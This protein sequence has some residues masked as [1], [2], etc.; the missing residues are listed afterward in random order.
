MNQIWELLAG[1]SIFIIGM[2]LLE[3]ALK[4]IAGRSFKLFLKKQTS[5]KFK[6]ILGGAVVT[7]LLQSSSIVNIMV[8]AFVG[9]K[10]L[11]MENA[12]ALMLGSNLGT[13][14]TSWIIAVVGFKLNIEELAWPLT[15]LAGLLWTI[16]SVQ[17]RFYSWVQFLLGFGFLLLGLHFM[18]TGVEGSLE[19]INLDQFNHYPAIIFL[20][21][22]AVITSIVQA[23]SATIALTLAVLHA[24][25]IDLYAAA[26]IVLGA[27]IGTT[28][29]LLILAQGKLPDKKRVALGNFLFNTISSVLAFFTIGPLLQFI[30]GPLSISDDLTALA[31][32]QTMVNLLGILLFFP[33]LKLFGK[34][35]QNRFTQAQ[36]D[37]SFIHKVSISEP[38]L[39][40]QATQEE[41]RHFMYHL[42]RYSLNGLGITNWDFKPASWHP[43]H[44]HKTPEEQYD[45]LKDLHGDIQQ[46]YVQ[47]QAGITDLD[48]TELLDQLIAALRNGMYGAKSMKD[49]LMDADQLRDSSNDFKFGYYELSKDRMT[50]FLKQI[51]P[52]LTGEEK[53][54]S[55]PL[56]SIINQV[57]DQYQAAVTE[58]YGKNRTS[59][60][61]DTELATLINYNRE[62]YTAK[63]SILLAIK[64][65]LLTPAE[66]AV[67][68]DLPGFIR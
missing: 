17:N 49:A 19:K 30:Q 16:L 22:G 55:G 47:L 54:A 12:L 5:N 48:Q 13:T 66:A 24:G 45:Y 39:A 61:T 31:S 14:F 9:A 28:T 56:L 34:F 40:M 10:V 37:T 65:L 35:L 57:A 41:I 18:Q 7:A 20:L 3:E 1:V 42:V 2:R 15:G 8:L 36:E 32:F 67:F 63:K 6:G 44:N 29:K 53:A 27:E 62:L 64:D 25:G 51:S 50:K 33:F 52:Y 11:Q 23:S 60:V 21:L 26:A 68:K 58:L 46:F 43:N 59:I 38:E 4:K